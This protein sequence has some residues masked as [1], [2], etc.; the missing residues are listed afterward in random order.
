MISDVMFSS[1]YVY[2]L[3]FMSMT[4]WAYLILNDKSV[5]ANDHIKV[6][7]H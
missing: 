4:W 7:V 1:D 5:G 6:G 2:H 3:Y